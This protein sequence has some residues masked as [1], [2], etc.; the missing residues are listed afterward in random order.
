MLFQFDRF[1]LL[2]FLLKKKKKEAKNSNENTVFKTQTLFSGPV[3]S[4]FSIIKKKKKF[5]LFRRNERDV[6]NEAVTQECI[7]L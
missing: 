7:V 3:E 1:S 6:S 5:E 4:T 2:N